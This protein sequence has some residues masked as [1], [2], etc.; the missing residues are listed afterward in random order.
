M[1]AMCQLY[2]YTFT[3]ISCSDSNLKTRK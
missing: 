3:L 1:N 2:V